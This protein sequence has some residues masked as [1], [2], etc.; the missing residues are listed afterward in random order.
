MGSHGCVFYS[1]PFVI[2]IDPIYSKTER[3]DITMGKRIA[4]APC[5]MCYLCERGR[6]CV[7]PMISDD[8]LKVGHRESFHAKEKSEFMNE[9][10][11]TSIQ[12]ATGFS[13]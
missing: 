8:A 4:K 1:V 13:S 3:M 6:K 10:A 2:G 12:K 11:F 7:N 5:G 9:L